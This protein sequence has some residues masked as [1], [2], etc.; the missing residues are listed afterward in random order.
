VPLVSRNTFS[1]A[2]RRDRPLDEPVRGR[3]RDIQPSQPRLPEYSPTADYRGRSFSPVYHC[4]EDRNI[5]AKRQDISSISYNIGLP[6]N[7]IHAVSEKRHILQSP[8]DIG[9]M[10][11]RSLSPTTRTRRSFE[12][13]TLEN[14]SYIPQVEVSCQTCRRQKGHLV[15]SPLGKMVDFILL[16][17]IKIHGVPGHQV[18]TI[19]NSEGH[20]VETIPVRSIPSTPPPQRAPQDGFDALL[21]IRRRS[22]GADLLY[23]HYRWRPEN[24]SSE[25]SSN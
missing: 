11:A 20:V 1:S 2:L 22:T 12:R 15:L 10:S 25:S 6:K 3:S 7:E 16:N 23:A 17:R 14:H 24:S 5:V 13:W 9:Y 19:H 21:R 4:K 18:A 8:I